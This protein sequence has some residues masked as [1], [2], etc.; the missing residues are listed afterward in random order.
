MKKQNIKKEYSI[1]MP[2]SNKEQQ[3]LK[4]ILLL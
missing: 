4:M 3:F 1:N 2:E